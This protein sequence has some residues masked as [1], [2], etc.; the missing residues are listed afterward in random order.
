MT[1]LK[2]FVSIGAMVLLVSATSLTAFAASNYST[3]AEALAGLTGKTV[4]SV[5]AEKTETGKTYGTIANEAGKLTEFKTEMLEVK[6]D[7]L[8]KKVQAGTITQEKANE[9]IAA[10]EKNQTT[11][12]GTGSA[13]IGKSLGAGFGCSNGNAQGKGQGQGNNNAQGR[14]QRNCT[15]Q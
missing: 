11:C 4:E 12:D 6:K 2:K 5:I 3:P 14:G 9:I 15:M 8:A 1:K 13:K 7:I 10:I